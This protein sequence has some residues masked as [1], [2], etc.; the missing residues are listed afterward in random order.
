MAKKI[1]FIAEIQRCNGIFTQIHADWKGVCEVD[2]L[3][4]FY[5][6]KN[7]ILFLLFFVKKYWLEKVTCKII[8]AFK[9]ILFNILF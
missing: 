1:L 5:L 7:F 3:I 2:K 8:I 4:F 6:I 9:N